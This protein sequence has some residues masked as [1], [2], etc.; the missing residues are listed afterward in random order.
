MPLEEILTRAYAGRRT[1]ARGGRSAATSR[2]PAKRARGETGES[3]AVEAKNE[4]SPALKSR[5]RRGGAKANIILAQKSLPVEVRL[6]IL[7]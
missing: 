6:L 4:A 2:S 1:N 3:V 7:T 5:G